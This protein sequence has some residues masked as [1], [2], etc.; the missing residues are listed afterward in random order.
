M[1]IIVPKGNN[2]KS[3]ADIKG[4]TL[5]FISPTSNS[6]NNASSAW[7][8]SEFG[9]VKDKDFKTVFSGKHNNFVLGLVSAE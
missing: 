8:Q 7:L 5:A 6:G 4:H 9:W 2:I 1:E 3:P